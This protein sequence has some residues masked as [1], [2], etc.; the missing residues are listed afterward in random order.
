MSGWSGD[1]EKSENKTSIQ[2][3]NIGSIDAFEIY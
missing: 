3:A 1:H 2:L